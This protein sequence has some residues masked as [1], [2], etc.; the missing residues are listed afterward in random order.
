MLCSGNKRNHIS[1]A[2]LMNVLQRLVCPPIEASNP[3]RSWRLEHRKLWPHAGLTSEILDRLERISTDTDKHVHHKTCLLQNPT[4]YV[5]FGNISSLKSQSAPNMAC[6]KI[7]A[8]QYT[9]VNTCCNEPRVG[10]RPSR[11]RWHRGST[12]EL[13]KRTPRAAMG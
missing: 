8:F 7:K 5:S 13:R 12:H 10:D 9:L 6:C 1:V 3:N 2:V 4:W 11:N